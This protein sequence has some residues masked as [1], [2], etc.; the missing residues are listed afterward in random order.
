MAKNFGRGWM[1]GLLDDIWERFE[2]YLVH[3]AVDGLVACSLWIFLFIFKLITKLFHIDGIAAVI[4]GHIHSV[5]SVL[6][7]MVFGVLFFIDVLEI[8]KAEVLKDEEKRKKG[9]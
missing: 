7:F 4:I 3:I 8:R 6:A 1:N 9:S 2:P 5:G